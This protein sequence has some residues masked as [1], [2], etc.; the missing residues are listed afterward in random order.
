MVCFCSNFGMKF[1]DSPSPVLMIDMVRIASQYFSKQISSV[2][3]LI[4]LYASLGSVRIPSPCKQQSP[5][6]WPSTMYHKDVN[7]S[8]QSAFGARITLLCFLVFQSLGT[9]YM[10]NGPVAWDTCGPLLKWACRRKPGCVKHAWSFHGVALTVR[11][12]LFNTQQYFF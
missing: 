5:G 12:R 9:K 8:W 1:W 7:V 2:G 10:V 11:L 4:V 3:V 6:L